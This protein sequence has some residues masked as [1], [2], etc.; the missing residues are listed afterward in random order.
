MT[1]PKVHHL[2]R[3]G[4]ANAM[5]LYGLTARA[6]RF[7]EER[8]LIE[9][10]RD[11]LNAR[12]Y[13]PDARRRL[14]WIVPLRRAGVSLEEIREVLRAEDEEGRGQE[15]ALRAVA[16]RQIELEA[17]LSAAKDATLTLQTAPAPQ[18]RRLGL[19][20]RA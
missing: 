18:P 3:L 4:L 14:D 9:A 12:F 10:R 5:R 15:C 6:L 11:R 17:Q 7:Y 16:R 1:E 20:A 2:P 8:G 13:D 19:A